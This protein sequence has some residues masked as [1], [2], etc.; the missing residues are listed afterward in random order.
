MPI[1]V[2]YDWA[3]KNEGTQLFVHMK[4]LKNNQQLFNATLYLQREEISSARLNWLLI[5]YPF[6]TIKVVIGIYWNA[7]LLWLKRVPFYSHPN[8]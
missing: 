1:D 4:N 8:N 3:F 5:S 7:F 2:Q 6:M